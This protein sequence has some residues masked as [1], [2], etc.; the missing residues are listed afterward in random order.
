[1]KKQARRPLPFLAIRRIIPNPLLI[2]LSKKQAAR[3]PHYEIPG[4]TVEEAAKG[5]YEFFKLWPYSVE[6]YRKNMERYRK[7]KEKNKKT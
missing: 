1:M 7:E 6:N 3:L 2:E 4:I 5:M